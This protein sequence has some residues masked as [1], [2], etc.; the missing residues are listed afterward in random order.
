MFIHKK[1]KYRV[2]PI[3]NEVL[4]TWRKKQTT[5]PGYK[6]EESYRH[7]EWWIE[8]STYFNKLFKK[9]GNAWHILRINVELLFIVFLKG[10][11]FHQNTS[12][13]ILSKF[14]EPC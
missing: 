8:P 4:A 7:N 12:V 14:V 1:D 9:E 13:H 10:Y 5:V 2:V 3:H 6:M 11:A